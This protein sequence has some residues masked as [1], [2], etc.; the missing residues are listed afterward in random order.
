MDPAGNTPAD[1]GK[2][3]DA[4][5]KPLRVL[6]LDDDAERIK[7]VEEGLAGSAVVHAASRVH[8]RIL[9]DLIA[10]FQPDVIIMDCQSP[11]R[12]TIE[13]L[14]SVVQ[15]NPKP[16]VMFVEEEGSERMAE[17]IEAGVSAYVIDGL[18]PKRVR[19]LIDIAI[20]R[21]QVM[22]GLRSEL[23]KTRDDLAARKV[24][25]RAKGLLMARQGLSEEE[26]FAAMRTMSQQRGKPLREIAE[27][28]I[29][30]LDLL[31]SPPTGRRD[32]QD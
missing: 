32:D 8:G 10:G 3:A 5:V 18:K 23:R 1:P 14:R 31:N 27:S 30:I 16:I 12:D 17:A 21:F 4:P 22:D 9:L 24:I 19:P 2:P 15:H 29:A 13:S 20:K 6:L 7:L 28:V 11:D 26:A 25:E